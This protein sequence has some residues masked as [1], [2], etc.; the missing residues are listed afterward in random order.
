[1]MRKCD[2]VVLVV[3]CGIAL[4][5]TGAMSVGGRMR[6]KTLMC[7][8]NLQKIAQAMAAYT[9]NYDGKMPTMNVYTY[10]GTWRAQNCIRVNYV[11]SQ[12]SDGASPRQIWMLLGCLFKAG[13]ITDGRTFYCPAT[14]GA[15]E[16]F[17][18]Y[19]NPAPWGSSIQLQVPNSGPDGNGNMWLRARKGYIYWPQGK[20]MVT[21]SFRNPYDGQP[22]GEPDSTNGWGRYA[23]G[24]PAP[25][26]KFADLGP[27]YAYAVDGEGQRDDSGGYKINTLFGDGHV[28]YQFVPRFT[29]PAT[30]KRLWICPYQGSRPANADPL[31]WYRQSD[32]Y[33][34][35][36]VTNICNYVYALEP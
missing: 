4:L 6:A 21:E 27:N 31:E 25:P 16:E 10:S 3:I 34:W 24:K 1:M 32:G 11:L 12:Y 9:D 19:S 29:D 28:K 8:A 13:L 5:S 36:S 35:D 15:M 33:W 17:L 14:T 7:T 22:L 20:Q 26:L 2:A 18:S 23:V 30:G